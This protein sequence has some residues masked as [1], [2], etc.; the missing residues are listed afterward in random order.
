MKIKP[1]GEPWKEYM[2]KRFPTSVHAEMFRVYYTLACY[3]KH[4]SWNDFGQGNCVILPIKITQKPF[5]IRAEKTK[6][7]EE[8]ESEVQPEVHVVFPLGESSSKYQEQV[9][10][11]KEVEWAKNVRP[12]FVTANEFKAAFGSEL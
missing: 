9:I 1:K 2:I 3:I 7:P 12:S 4:D 11:P 8:W 6:L 5:K 10:V